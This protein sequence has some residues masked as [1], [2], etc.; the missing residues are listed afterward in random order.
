MANY[1]HRQIAMLVSLFVEEND[2]NAFAQLYGL[3]YNKIYNY[4]CYYLKDTYLAQDALQEIYIQ[5][6]KKLPD[7]SR[8]CSFHGL[9][10]LLFMYAM[11]L[12]SVR[13]R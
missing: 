9:I 11:I 13:A 6:M 5:V 4:A 8:S 1:N 10:R 7:L 2:S 12:P 3:T